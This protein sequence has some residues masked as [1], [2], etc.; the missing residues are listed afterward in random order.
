MPDCGSGDEMGPALRSEDQASISSPLTQSGNQLNQSSKCEVETQ[1]LIRAFKQS[2]F[3]NQSDQSG[4]TVPNSVE[5]A[6]IHWW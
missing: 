2:A 5:A 6:V 1:L 4:E 3:N